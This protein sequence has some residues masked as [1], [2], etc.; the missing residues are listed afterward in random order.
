MSASS[1]ANFQVTPFMFGAGEEKKQSGKAPCIK[2]GGFNYKLVL[3]Y[4]GVHVSKV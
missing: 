3:V 1:P 4:W 2:N